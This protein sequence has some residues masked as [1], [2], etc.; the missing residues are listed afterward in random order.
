MECLPHTKQLFVVCAEQLGALSTWQWS[1]AS[2]LAAP[3]LVPGRRRPGS[4]VCPPRIPHQHG[5]YKPRPFHHGMLLGT[6]IPIRLFLWPHRR[7]RG[8]FGF[9]SFCPSVTADASVDS[10]RWQGSQWPS[11]RNSLVQCQSS[12]PWVALIGSCHEGQVLP[13]RDYGRE[14]VPP[15]T[16]V[17]TP[18]CVGSGHP[19]ASQLACPIV[20]LE[21]RSYMPSISSAGWAHVSQYIQIP[22]PQ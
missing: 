15:S 6:A 8:Y 22:P 19:A 12:C 13:R 16:A 14:I 2:P 5:P 18:H 4:P 3:G 9:Q 21:G 11:H 10:V 1:P 17:S 20:W 7:Y